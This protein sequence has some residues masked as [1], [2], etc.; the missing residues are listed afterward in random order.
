M[1]DEDTTTENW[2]LYEVP[3]RHIA[4]ITLNRP[5][6]RNAIQFPDMSHRLME[7]VERAEDDDDIKVVILTGAGEHFCAGEDVRKTPVETFGLEKG[8][9][10]PQ[11]LRIRGITRNLDDDFMLSDKTV[12]AAVR[13]AALGL[14]FKLAL[15]C[16]LIVAADDATFGRPQ[17]RI[18]LA[19][20]DMMLPVLLLRLGINRGYEAL[21]TGRT[22]TAEELGSWGVLA[23]VVP[24]AELDDEALRYARA[25][26]NHSTDGLMLGR[27]AMQMFWSMMGIAQWN[28]FCQV[29][30]PLFTNLVW[31][32][33]EAN[34]YKERLRTG[35]ASAALKSVYR[36]W[37][38]LGF[39]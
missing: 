37:E 16:D 11:S 21:I 14:G 9:R 24:G 1:A 36:R 12:V 30:H 35:S 39:D 17:T 25:V 33:D 23:S 5:E 38:D 2:V 20:F 32:E 19:G 10:L 34:L 22:L 6:R 27:K 26:A 3:E 18:G 8:K 28:A 4:K 7:A 31:R 29:A 15:E 13:G